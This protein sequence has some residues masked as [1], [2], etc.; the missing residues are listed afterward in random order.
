MLAIFPRELY[1]VIMIEIINMSYSIPN[2]GDILTDVN[3][4]ITSNDFIGILGKNGAGK[5]TLIDIMM[6]F[7]KPS[8]GKVSILG[9][10]PVASNRSVFKEVAYLSQDISLKDDISIEA[11]FEFH[12][13]F[14]INYSVDEERR[15]MDIFGLDYKSKIGGHS[16]GQKRRIQIIAALASRPKIL[17]I[18]E[19]TAVLDPDA[20]YLFFKLIKEVNAT[21]STVVLLATNIVEDLKDRIDGL[22]FIRNTKLEHHNASHIDSLFTGSEA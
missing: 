21:Q 15:L 5:T 18:D 9:S 10:D 7:R 19:I 16:T 22:Y 14:F 6:G 13:Y 20:R 3:L 4:N 17:F 8:A 11:F 1:I 2:S 12:K